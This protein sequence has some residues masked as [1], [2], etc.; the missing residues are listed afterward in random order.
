VRGSSQ[1]RAAVPS[2]PRWLAAGA[3][4][5]WFAASPAFGAGKPAAVAEIK[6]EGGTTLTADTIEYYLGISVDDLY[7]TA[8]VERGFRK[9]WDSGLVEEL[10]I[11]TEDTAPGKVT[12]VVT[13]KERPKVSEFAFEG[14]K[15]LSTS[16]IKE[17]LDGM[18]IVLRRNVPL[19]A[20]EVQKFKQAVIDVYGKEGYAAAVIEPTVLPSGTNMRRVVFKI[21][22]GTKIKIGSIKFEGNQKY[23]D[24]SLRGALK[25]T[26]QKGIRWLFSKKTVWSKE[27]WGEDS[28]NLKKYYMNRGYRDIIVGEPKV[29]LVAGNPTGKTQKEKKYRMVVTIPV[30]EGPQ[31]RMG[32]LTIEGV[33]KFNAETLR[34]L[35]EVKEGKIYNYSKVEAGNEAVRNVYQGN[36]YIYAYTNQSWSEH[37]KRAGTVDVVV[38]VYEGERFK[39]GRLEFSGNTRTQEKVLRREFRLFEGDWMDM[40]TFK[41]SLFKVNQLGYFKL[42]EDPLEFKFDEASKTVNVTVKGEEVGRTD[43]QFGAGYS[44]LDGLFGQFMFNTRNFLGRGSTLGLATSFGRRASNYSLS[45][46]EPY[47]MDRRMVVGGSLYKSDMNLDE[48]TSVQQYERASKGLSLIWG[49]GVGI[50]G[51]FSTSYAYDKSTAKYTTSRVLPAN[52]TPGFPHTPPLPPPVKTPGKEQLFFAEY[53]GVTSSI[54]PGYTYDSRDDPFDPNS[55]LSYFARLRFAGGPLGGDFYYLRPEIGASAFIP[56]TKKMIFAANIEAGYIRPF[57]G[58]QVPVYERYRLGGERSLRGF[59]FLSV[60]PRKENG[61]YF[62]D[63]YGV[64]LGG[65]RYLQINAEYQFRLGGPV[66]FILFMDVGN[67]W[68]DVQGWDLSHL[69]YGTG[70][71][72]RIFMP[73]FQ[74]PLRFIYGVNLDPYT[75]LYPKYGIPDEKKSNF[76]F[77]IGTTF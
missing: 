46:S 59:E 43:I 14:N 21:D 22:E 72:L 49:V 60:L 67:T 55:G 15:K 48:T 71:E 70:A 53:K 40:G 64:E 54:T 65:D 32:T 52:D 63:Q 18:G 38:N 26:K 10:T 29:D 37:P 41:K 77:S 47:F 56:V 36:G 2:G 9:L 19:R 75:G 76:T 23:G 31:Y 25:K 42:K 30:Q 11:E 66:K 17:K 35:Y 51:Q 20:S 33:S 12:L 4:I 28:E 3:V 50:F 16:T 39:L 13:V 57:G 7:D 69:R 61:D 73:I 58:K 45:Y 24:G 1:G 6:V 27:N 8:A 34:R 68:M 74:A 5:L 44:E 62:R